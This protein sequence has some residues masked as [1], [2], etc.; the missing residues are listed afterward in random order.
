MNDIILLRHGAVT[1]PDLAHGQRSDPGLSAEGHDQ[2][3][4]AASVLGRIDTLVCS[5]SLRSRQTAAHL[6]GTPTL[7]DRW[8]ERDLGDWEGRPWDDCWAEVPREI[9]SDPQAFVRYTPPDGEP[10]QTVADRVVCALDDLA[11]T[12]SVGRVVVVTH[13][14]P[15]R[16]AVAHLTD[17]SAADAMALPVDCGTGWELH[18]TGTG[19]KV[20]RWEP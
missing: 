17:T 3:R 5:P 16:L 6:S 15:I 14:G 10:T 7:D 4:H 2:A 12:R 19:W 11:A 9:T 8:A 13:A 18:P 1:A 20:R